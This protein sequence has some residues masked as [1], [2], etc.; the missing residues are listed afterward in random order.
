MRARAFPEVIA[1]VAH[2]VA[3]AH[4]GGVHVGGRLESVALWFTAAG[5]I[6][7]TT[8]QQRVLAAL[9]DGGDAE[10]ARR[11]GT[12]APAAESRVPPATTEREFDPTDPRLDRVTGFLSADRFDEHIELF[13]EDEAALLLIDLGGIP[14]VDPADRILRTVADRIAAQFRN[15][16]LVARLGD[17]R[18][19][20]VV[21]GVDRSAMVIRAKQLLAT[22]AEPLS[23]DGTSV[24]VVPTIALAHQAGLVDLEEMVESAAA[25]LAGTTPT[26]TGRLV[27]AA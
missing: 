15:E 24:D 8:S 12:A 23:V 2:D 10:R 27:L 7:D 25:A 22:I 5:E 18:I 1:S 21:A 3:A 9:A 20:I 14:A 11:I 17:R 6:V 13:D 26:G 16:D 19:A 4:V